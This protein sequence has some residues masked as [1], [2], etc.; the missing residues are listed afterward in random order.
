MK[1]TIGCQTVDGEDCVFPFIYKEKIYN[2]CTKED[3]INSLPWCAT[4]VKENGEIFRSNWGD[5]EDIY[6]C[7]D[8]EESGE[9]EITSHESSE[10]NNILGSYIL[11]K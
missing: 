6:G 9:E 3:S 1:F 7:F 10:K 11:F 2:K 5:C 4:N 8:G